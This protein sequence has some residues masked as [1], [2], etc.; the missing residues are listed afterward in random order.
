[1]KVCEARE[2]EC[3]AG[4][5][6]TLV[7][8]T[9]VVALL[10]LYGFVVTAEIPILQDEEDATSA[11]IIHSAHS[12]A[13]SGVAFSY[14]RLD[15]RCV[16]LAAYSS[17]PVS[18][19]LVGGDDAPWKFDPSFFNVDCDGKALVN[20]SAPNVVPDE[21]RTCFLP[22]YGTKDCR[23][24][25][26]DGDCDVGQYRA[27]IIEGKGKKKKKS[28]LKHSPN[29]NC[30]RFNFDGGDCAV[31]TDIQNVSAEGEAKKWKRFRAAVVRLKFPT[32]GLQ[33]QSSRNT[34]G[35]ASHG[36]LRTDGADMNS[37]RPRRSG[38]ITVA[39]DQGSSSELSTATVHLHNPVSTLTGVR[40]SFLQFIYFKPLKTG[41][42]TTYTL[43]YNRIKGVCQE[44]KLTNIKELCDLGRPGHGDIQFKLPFLRKLGFDL[45]DVFTFS[46]VRN[47]WD[48]QVSWFF[49]DRFRKNKE[50]R[51]NRSLAYRAEFQE[52]LRR[53]GSLSFDNFLAGEVDESGLSMFPAVNYLLRYESL[54]DDLEEMLRLLGV[55]QSPGA[56]A[57]LS[58]LV[59][60]HLVVIPLLLA[61]EPGTCFNFPRLLAQQIEK[62][63]FRPTSQA[64][65]VDRMYRDYYDEVSIEIVRDANKRT[66]ELLNYTF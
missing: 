5:T 56:G 53:E 24:F 45:A 13:G 38:C 6:L 14:G 31:H 17:S 51:Q 30:S 16:Q 57:S 59:R 58:E 42:E 47:P 64:Y 65:T 12:A 43:L 1:M 61:V 63:K 19:A 25:I 20:S 54:N 34:T 37:R 60:L 18:L 35:G 11:T 48:R 7:A 39:T 62:K 52:H 9:A 49:W 2:H 33:N 4:K 55:E 36:N 26:G 28:L 41:S 27:G 8:G 23:R 21:Y 46:G 50:L 29:F 32:A 40:G 22:Q 15:E 3:C 44:G 10:L 66:I